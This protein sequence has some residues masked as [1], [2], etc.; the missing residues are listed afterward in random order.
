M[1]TRELLTKLDELEAAG[2][3][4]PEIMTHIEKLLYRDGV[5][6]SGDHTAVD[7]PIMATGP[8][9]E[10]ITGRMRMDNTDVFEVMKRALKP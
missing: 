10:M 9:A 1:T 8:G 3:L 7:V 4:T 2:T 5:W 6:A